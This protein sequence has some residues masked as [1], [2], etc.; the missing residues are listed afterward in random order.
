[1]YF[2]KKK[3]YDPEK[4]ESDRSK[5]VTY[6]NGAIFNAFLEMDGILNKSALA[7]QY[8][9]KSQ[10]WLSQK[11][12]GSMIDSK[13][14]SFTPDEARKMAEAFRDIARRLEGLAAEIDAAADTE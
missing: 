1:M 11:I 4:T 3:P 8:F 12:N 14:Q 7:R 6:R 13:S 10:S 9:E 5:V 2:G